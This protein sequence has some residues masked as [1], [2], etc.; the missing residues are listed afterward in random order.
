MLWNERLKQLRNGTGVSLKDMARLVGVSEA[1]AQR[2]ESGAI[3]QVPYEVI[4][5]YAEK[6]GVS[7]SYI[8][9]WDSPA[10]DL[11]GQEREHIRKY[12]KL[13]DMGRHAVDVV[14]DMEL[15]RTLQEG[16]KKEADASA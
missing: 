13:D 4:I 2:Y 5:A 3:H 1:T 12:R 11:T 16:S 14:T 9:G 6:F 15:N 8:M 7:P 10:T